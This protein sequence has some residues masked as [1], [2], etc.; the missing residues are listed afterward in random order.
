M[1]SRCLYEPSEMNPLPVSWLF[2]ELSDNN[3]SDHGLS[4]SS[5]VAVIEQILKVTLMLGNDTHSM[6]N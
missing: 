2:E 4:L 1:Q 5:S 3:A 6:P